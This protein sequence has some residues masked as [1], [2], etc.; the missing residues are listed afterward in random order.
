MHQM[1]THT[2]GIMATVVWEHQQ[3]LH[4][5]DHKRLHPAPAYM[6][7]FSVLPSNHLHETLNNNIKPLGGVIIGDELSRVIKRYG[8]ESVCHLH[9]NTGQAEQA[10]R[11]T[12]CCQAKLPKLAAGKLG[13]PLRPWCALP[14]LSFSRKVPASRIKIQQLHAGLHKLPASGSPGTALD[15][16]PDHRTDQS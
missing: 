1:E 3:Y 12:S 4:L 13:Q 9:G 11:P 5:L 6:A 15:K 7:G 10:N 16:N 2:P 8:F 14:E